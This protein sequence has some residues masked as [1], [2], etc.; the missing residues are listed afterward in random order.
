MTVPGVERLRMLRR[1]TASRAHRG[2]QDHGYLE[3]AAG[4]V[5]DL[6]RLV[7][8]LIHDES[9]EITEHDVDDGPHPCHRRAN[10]QTGKAWLGDWR[11]E[12]ALFAE[13]FDESVQHFE[14]CPGFG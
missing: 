4:H 9:A 7:R 13:L 14:R 1:R 3:L 8:D 2:T 10:R 5:M 12:D 11:I 6:G